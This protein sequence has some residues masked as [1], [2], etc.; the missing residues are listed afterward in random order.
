MKPIYMKNYAFTNV[1]QKQ[2]DQK[3]S[4]GKE[5][6]FDYTRVKRDG[7]YGMPVDED[8]DLNDPLTT[9]DILRVCGLTRVYSIVATKAGEARSSN[10]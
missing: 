3:N 4:T 8:V 2:I 6:L 5:P 1:A 10:L 7:Y 9:D